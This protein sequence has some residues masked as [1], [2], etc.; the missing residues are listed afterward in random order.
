MFTT[1]RSWKICWITF[2]P[3]RVPEADRGFGLPSC[4]PTKGTTTLDAVVLAEIEASSPA[5]RAEGSSPRIAWDAT[6]GWWREPMPGATSTA[7]F[8]FVMNAGPI[9]IWPF[10]PSLVL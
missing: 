6:V 5:L 2:L 3:F 7:D 8:G 1:P 9:F 10:S 4:T